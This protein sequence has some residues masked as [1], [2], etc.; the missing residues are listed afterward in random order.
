[1][2]SPKILNLDTLETG[3]EKVI[4][5][6]GVEYAMRP[7][8]V[9]DFIEQMRSISSAENAA[10]EEAFSLVVDSIVRAFPGLERKSVMDMEMPKLNAIY[11][12]IRATTEEEVTEGNVLAASE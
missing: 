2:A 12:F 11:E 4:V 1:M 6:G 5:I 3:S 8:S 9:Q 7:F 10:P